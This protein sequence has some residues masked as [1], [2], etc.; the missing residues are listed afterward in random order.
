M[1]IGHRYLPIH[2]SKKEIRL[3]ELLPRSSS[4]EH[5]LIP[6]CRIFHASLHDRPNFVALS[7][8]W[9]DPNDVRIILVEN[10]GVRVTKNLYDAIMA[11]RRARD[12]IVIWID[13]LCINQSDNEE[14]SWQ[15]GLM[16]D[17]YRQATS[18]TAWL[19][20]PDAT[21]DSVMD[22]LNFLGDRAQALGMDHGPQRYAKIW[23][24]LA[25]NPLEVYH[26]PL[27][28]ITFVTLKG[29]M[30]S[31][32]RLSLY[33]LF[34][35]ISGW[36]DQSRLLPIAGMEVFFTRPWWGRMW[37][38]QEIT[39]PENAYL[40]CGSRSITRRRCS[41]AL[42]ACCA[43]WDVV[44]TRYL[45]QPSSLTAYHYQIMSK[46]FQHKADVML[47]SRNIYSNGGFPLAALLRATCVG[48]TNLRQHGPQHLASSDPRD[49]IF[50]LLSIAADRE[51]LARLGVYPDYTKSCKEVY[52]AAMAAML[53]QGHL[54][55][56]SLCQNSKFDTD[57][58]S[59]VP[60]WSRSMTDM[61]QDVETDHITLY[62]KF[63]AS[64]AK[65]HGKR[66]S[67]ITRDGKV[68]ALSVVGYILDEISAPGY[69]RNRAS[70]SEVPPGE[71]FS[72]PVSW[73]AE[74]LRLTYKAKGTYKDFGER[75][76]AVVRTSIGEV[77]YDDSSELVR[78]GNDRFLEAVIMLQERMHIIRHESSRQ[79]LQ[80]LVASLSIGELIMGKIAELHHRLVSEIIGKSLR[81]LP[82]ITKKGR[83]V[84]SSEHVKRRDLVAVIKGVQVPFIL[85]RHGESHYRLVG[86]A[87]VDGIMDGEALG[88]ANCTNITLV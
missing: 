32:L 24:D 26:R 73:L 9:G 12:R 2:Q 19:G 68:E 17:I 64:R 65:P 22:Y 77:G 5:R 51:E 45:V 30:F 50:A 70:S 16:A 88:D 15:V 38:L 43:L 47:S 84:L 13:A 74:I 23:Q 78:V 11:L 71:R 41:A 37:I 80:R 85:R 31:V 87:Y 62:P 72:W 63:A 59:W 33:M 57:L 69:F 27:L 53:K 49:K 48:S 58:A 55:L 54:S 82:F 60:D 1:A 35:Q 7:Y 75:L 86:E 67:I 44:K 25:A 4:P 28:R 3:L 18:V 6:A 14:K 8:V 46:G 81:R 21:S 52:S 36:H 76:R 10:S 56:L 61:L 20:L 29:K 66:V 79:E 42:N 39:L 34:H 83:L 40:V